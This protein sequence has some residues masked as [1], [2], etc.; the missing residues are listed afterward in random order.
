MKAVIEL[1]SIQVQEAVEEY[2]TRRNLNAKPGSVTLKAVERRD[3]MDRSTGGHTITAA[4]EVEIG[5][6]VAQ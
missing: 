6:L 2:L 5:D 1:T 4:V 3:P